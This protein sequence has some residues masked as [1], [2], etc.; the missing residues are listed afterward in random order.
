M[1]PQLKRHKTLKLVSEGQGRSPPFWGMGLRSFWRLCKVKEQLSIQALDHPND[2]LGHDHDYASNDGSQ[3]S[4]SSNEED[5]N[6]GSGS[7][8][9]LEDEDDDGAPDEEEDQA[10]QQDGFVGWLAGLNLSDRVKDDCAMG[11]K[12]M[13]WQVYVSLAAVPPC[14]ILLTALHAGLHVTAHASFLGSI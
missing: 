9:E 2:G 4:H 6:N 5:E 1:T 10:S 7:D 11:C 14:A 8:S 3:S 12:K 13:R